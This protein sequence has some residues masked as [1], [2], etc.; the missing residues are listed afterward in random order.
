MKAEDAIASQIN[1]LKEIGLDDAKIKAILD[2]LVK[3]A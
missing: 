2:N 1:V 3:K